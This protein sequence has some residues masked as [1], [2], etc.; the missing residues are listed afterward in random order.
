MTDCIFCKIVKKEIP[1]KLAYEDDNI[2]AFD[3]INPVAKVHILFVPKNHMDAFEDL[4]DDNILSSVRHGI[5]KIVEQNDLIGKG[6]KVVVNGGGGQVINHL[7]FHLI[8][9]TGLHA[10]IK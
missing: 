2:V 7:H 3:D 8:G 4:T 9:P 5:Q 6:Y 1:K 10:P